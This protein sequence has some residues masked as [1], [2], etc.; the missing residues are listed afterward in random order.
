M[1]RLSIF[2]I[3]AGLSISPFIGNNKRSLSLTDSNKI[4][5]S[6]LKTDSNQIKIIPNY[7]QINSISEL[8]KLFKNKPVFLD[9]W[10]TWC[11]PC[12]EEFK[13]SKPL[14]EYLTKN[15]IEIIYVSFDKEKD[16]SVWREIIK[17][18]ELFGNHVRANKSLQDSLTTLIWG[19]ID[20]YSIPNYLLFN[21]NGRLV[22]KNNLPPDTGIKLFKQIEGDL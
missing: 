8:L 15:G 4:N 16:D 3:I 6:I 9:L 11:N 18:N 5:T 20:A 17:S 14:Y 19:A 10:A 2:L 12:L 21:K 7:K 22:N 1:M 13:Y